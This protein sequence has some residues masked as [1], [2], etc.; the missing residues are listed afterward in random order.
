MKVIIW[1][2]P[3]YS[4]THSY[5]HNGYYRAFK[6]L[7]YETHWISDNQKNIDFNNSLIITEHFASRDLPIVDSSTYFVHYLGNKNDYHKHYLGRAGRLID[8]RYNANNWHDKNYDYDLDRE[9]V[10]KISEG[11]YYEGKNELGYEVAY[12]TWATDLLPDEINMDDR[13]IQREKRIHYIGTVGGGRGGLFNCLKA[14]DYYD[15]VPHI[16]PFYDEC[17][18][19]GVEFITN[20]P[21]DNPLDD[22]TVKKLIQKS[23]LAPD[24][25]HDAML[26]WGYIPCRVMKNISYGQLG[27]TNSKAVYDFFKGKVLYSNDGKELFNIG[28]ENM[29]NYDLIKEQMEMVRNEHT[30]INRAKDLIKI[31]ESK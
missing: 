16:M 26:D 1:G 13:F 14:P 31:Y 30:Y 20:C 2:Y 28:I 25:R 10:E 4:H 19:N 9:A 8:L 5:I 21:W 11:T 17:V 29:N 6:S 27:I 23:L 3:L 22:E 12:T 18:N 24:F 15:T 7:G